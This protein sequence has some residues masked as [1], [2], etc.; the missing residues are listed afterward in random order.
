MTNVRTRKTSRRRQPRK[1]SPS[2]LAQFHD[3]PRPDINIENPDD[4]GYINVDPSSKSIGG[5][6]H[7]ASVVFHQHGDR[8]VPVKFT[9]PVFGAFGSIA[10][11]LNY[12]RAKD[13]PD[14]MRYVPRFRNYLHH[15]SLLRR[16]G[17][18]FKNIPNFYA[19]A[20]EAFIYFLKQH[21]DI[22]EEFMRSVEPFTSFDIRKSG[23][24]IEGNPI[25]VVEWHEKM[26]RWLGILTLVREKYH[27]ADGRPSD[28]VF[29]EL[30]KAAK[31]KP[32][33]PI[34]EGVEHIVT[35]GKKEEKDAKEE[36][37]AEG[38][39]VATA[40]ILADDPSLKALAEQLK[41]SGSE[42]EASAEEA[43][44]SEQE[45]PVE[46]AKDAAQQEQTQEEAA[47]AVN[48]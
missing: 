40:K 18:Q 34:Y 39:E 33:L 7:P 28:E 6:L 43:P 3:I 32:D 14:N 41:G 2:I 47:Q 36:Y 13:F 21:K 17:V 46:E 27:E 25:H 31:D 29:A 44:E 45:S 22:E 19:I 24:D 16:K 23:V 35:G 38:E 10:A 1:T 15:E 5:V 9:H 12:I 20:M 26:A 4:T 42:E 11:F 30:I 37:I 48:S 8:K